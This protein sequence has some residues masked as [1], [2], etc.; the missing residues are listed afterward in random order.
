MVD[1]RI[2]PTVSVV[3]VNWNSKD[4]LRDCLASLEHQTEQG[5]ETIVVDNGSSDGSI[6]MLG[7]DFPWVVV[8]DARENLGF[9]EACNRGIAQA[10]GEWVA[11]LNNDAIASPTWIADLRSAVRAAGSD[12]GMVQSRILFKQTP[13]KT[14]STGVLI[15]RDGW[16]I[17]RAYN[18]DVNP[19]ETS[20]E[21]F[22]VS[23]GAALYRRKMLDDIRLASGFFDRTFFM[24]YE[25]VDL[26][27][28][29][30]LAGWSAIYQPG[31]TV[32]HAYNASSGRRGKYFVRSQCAK[33]RVRTV[34]KNGSRAYI[35]ASLFRMFFELVWCVTKEGL[36]ALAG[37]RA[38]IRD[39]LSQR[40]AVDTVVRCDRR[41]LEKRW[42]RI[43][44]TEG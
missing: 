5:F 13:S 23:A 1:P 26:G 36:R 28:R 33:N 42:I 11:T 15:G 8:V 14:N 7:A 25:D 3:I 27:W 10:A 24:Y 17:D 40:R 41:A 12:L 2:S 39:G 35:A 19:S 4:D 31:A 43:G 44:A 32:H 21:V 9:A 6:E 38:A 30:R 18:R 16:F 29:G 22:C 20:D 37:Y 34:L